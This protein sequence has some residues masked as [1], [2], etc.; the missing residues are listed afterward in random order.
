MAS[1]N[2]SSHGA[3]K[4]TM[5]DSS[6]NLPSKVSKTKENEP[7]NKTNNFPRFLIMTSLNPSI[8]LKHISPWFIQKAIEGVLV[9]EPKDISRLKSGDV[10][11]EINNREHCEKLLRWTN[12]IDIQTETNIPIRVSPHK[13]LN[14]SKGVIKTKDIDMCKETEISKE[15]KKQGVV[16]VKCVTRKTPQGVIRTGTYFLTFDTPDLPKHVTAA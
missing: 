14:F 11:I 10:L 12:I 6:E 2:P 7:Q 9:S 15:L 8:P 16:D 13:I 5:S 3:I 4:R 1:K